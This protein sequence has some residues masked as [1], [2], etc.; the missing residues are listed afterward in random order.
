MSLAKNLNE[1]PLTTDTMGVTQYTTGWWV[2]LIP[3]LECDWSSHPVFA[4]P[5]LPS[6]GGGI[7]SC[8]FLLVWSS[9]LNLFI[10]HFLNTLMWAI[11]AP[12]FHTQF[13]LAPLI[14]CSLMVG[15]CGLGEHRQGREPRREDFVDSA[16]GAHAI[17]IYLLFRLGSGFLPNAERV[18]SLLHVVCVL[19]LATGVLAIGAWIN[20]RFLESATN[21]LTGSPPA[22]SAGGSGFL[23]MA[24][25]RILNPPGV[26]FSESLCLYPH[27]YCCSG[28]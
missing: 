23:G 5:F 12:Y 15:I 7:T 24:L 6:G 21:V 20:E 13:W 27:R 14:L 17:V 8:E 18:N 25:R 22:A 11:G 2:G 16:G 26:R 1:M 3:S 28:P 10:F 9:A 19:A 4:Y